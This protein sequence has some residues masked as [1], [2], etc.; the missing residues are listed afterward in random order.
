M[1]F[2]YRNLLRW[3]LLMGSEFFE[4]VD[5]RPDLD[6]SPKTLLYLFTVY[7]LKNILLSE[8]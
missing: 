5:Y 4:L 8:T 2:S 3:M 7:N 6:G 1:S